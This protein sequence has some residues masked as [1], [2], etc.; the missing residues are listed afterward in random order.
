MYKS[1]CVCVCVCVCVSFCINVCYL[2]ANILKNSPT[3]NRMT[4]DL[5]SSSSSWISI[6]SKYCYCDQLGVAT[7]LPSKCAS[8][9]VVLPDLDIHFQGHTIWHVNIFKTMR[10]R[11]FWQIFKVSNLLCYFRKRLELGQECIR[12]LLLS[13]IFAIEWHHCDCSILCPWPKFSRSNF[14]TCISRKGWELAPNEMINNEKNFN[15]TFIHCD[16]LCRIAFL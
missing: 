3:Q 14:K 1:V 16:N 8:A 10:A 11:F 5:F 7:H 2:V 6:S 15:I 13:L 4:Q 9:N 12:R